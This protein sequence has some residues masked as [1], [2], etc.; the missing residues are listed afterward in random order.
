MLDKWIRK[1]YC[2]FKISSDRINKYSGYYSVSVCF[3]QVILHLGLALMCFFIKNCHELFFKFLFKLILKN[4]FPFPSPAT[5]N[6]VLLWWLL[7]FSL[8]YVLIP[9]WI[10]CLWDHKDTWNCLFFIGCR[11]G[12]RDESFYL[13]RFKNLDY[14]ILQP[15]VKIHLTG[16]RND[17]CKLLFRPWIEKLEWQNVSCTVA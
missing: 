7:S 4:F 11:D 2:D 9:A 8:C 1:N 3:P 16:L 10:L 13:K 5:C 15:E 17:Y 14:S 12:V 6:S